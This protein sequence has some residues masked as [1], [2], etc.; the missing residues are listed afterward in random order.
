[1][2]MY[3]LLCLERTA[4]CID[5]DI[6]LRLRPAIYTLHEF[7]H[8]RFVLLGVSGSHLNESIVILQVL[9]QSDPQPGWPSADYPIRGSKSEAMR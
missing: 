9:V 5:R 8:H 7:C 1:M 6:Y 2:K 3:M 4:V